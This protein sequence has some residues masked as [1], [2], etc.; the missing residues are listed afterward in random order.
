MIAFKTSCARR[1]D[2]VVGRRGRVFAD[3]YH[4]RPLTNPAQVR[5]ALCDVLNN[6]RRH[7]EDATH[8]ENAAVT[9]EQLKQTLGVDIGQLLRGISERGLPAGPVGV[10]A[11]PP[12]PRR[13]G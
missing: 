7:G 4:A 9:N 5:R 3:R 10:P 8:T 13:N 12:P 11:P 6:W 2:G 1:L